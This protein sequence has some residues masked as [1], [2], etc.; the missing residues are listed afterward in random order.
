M[1]KKIPIAPL[2]IGFIQSSYTHSGGTINAFMENTKQTFNQYRLADKN[3][4]SSS[5]SFVQP[6]LDITSTTQYTSSS[7]AAK[8]E[9]INEVKRMPPP[10]NP[11]KQG[12][13]WLIDKHSKGCA[14]VLDV[15]DNLELSSSSSEDE[16]EIRPIGSRIQI[17]RVK[18]PPAEVPKASPYLFRGSME[19]PKSHKAMGEIPAEKQQSK[20]AFAFLKANRPPSRHKTP[21]TAL[22]LDL[23]ETP[24]TPPKTQKELEE[25]SD[26]SQTVNVK[27]I[28]SLTKEPSPMTS[29]T[30]K[31]EAEPEDDYDSFSSSKSSLLTIITN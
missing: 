28:N 27:G 16:A 21:H 5:I 18:P 17:G 15:F 30:N 1:K 25:Y 24:H 14:N 12:F 19:P 9:T 6:T 23:P 20:R 10:K 8:A 4:T 2:G 3:G 22:G 26:Y 11:S 13:F 29:S 31:V 7:S